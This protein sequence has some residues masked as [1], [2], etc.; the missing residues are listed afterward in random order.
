MIGIPMFA[1]QWY[2]T[3]KYVQH[4]IGVKLDIETL[5][6]DVLKEAVTTVIEDER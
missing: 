5:T 4:K 1:D 3:E 6:E 2:N